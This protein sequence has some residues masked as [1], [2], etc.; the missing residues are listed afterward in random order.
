MFDHSFMETVFRYAQVQNLL[1]AMVLVFRP[2]TKLKWIGYYFLLLTSR[3]FLVAFSTAFTSDFPFLIH[4]VLFCEVLCAF[5]PIFLLKIF[6]SITDRDICRPTLLWWFIP[7]VPFLILEFAWLGGFLGAF[8]AAMPHAPS[9]TMCGMWGTTVHRD[10]WI[11]WCLVYDAFLL[12]VLFRVD[13]FRKS[14]DFLNLPKKNKLLFRWFVILVIVDLLNGS[15]F[16]ITS[17]LDVGKINVALEWLMANLPFIL[18]AILTFVISYLVLRYPYIFNADKGIAE[19]MEE[20]IIDQV[21]SP[22]EK[23]VVGQEE[24]KALISGLIQLFEVE[25][26][27]LDQ[28][29][30]LSVLAARL[31]STNNK[32]S[33]CINSHWKKNFNQVLKEYRVTFAKVIL[34]DPKSIEQTIYSVALESGFNTEASFYSSFK[35]MTG[36]TPNEFRNAALDL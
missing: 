24:Q 17:I 29:V 10:I 7:I 3:Y 22:R 35:G 13:K 36:F 16:I 6:R 20:K 30:N 19:T 12:Y 34:S 28:S 5:Y 11:A 9:Q 27:Y 1:L 31:N 15:T 8:N 18:K 21:L 14:D 26:I 32:I 25:R 2:E 23:N 4:G 33:F